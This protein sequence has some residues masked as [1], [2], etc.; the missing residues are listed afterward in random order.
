[1]SEQV[2][3]LP[4]TEGTI[5]NGAETDVSQTELNTLNDTESTST[6]DVVQL[7]AIETDGKKDSEG[8]DQGETYCHYF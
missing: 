2:D 7:E 3:H 1:M 6:G 4:I 8:S 5:S